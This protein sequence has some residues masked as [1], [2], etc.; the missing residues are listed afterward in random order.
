MDQLPDGLA[1]AVELWLHSR[2]PEMETGP[3]AVYSTRRPDVSHEHEIL[4][5]SVPRFRWRRGAEVTVLMQTR[6][7]CRV[8]NPS[9]GRE[10]ASD[11]TI[12]GTAWRMT[13][14][15]WRASDIRTDRWVS[16]AVCLK[17]GRQVGE[18]IGVRQV[19]LS[20]R[21]YENLVLFAL[22]NVSDTAAALGCACRQAL[23]S[24]A[25]GFGGHKHFEFTLPAG[26]ERIIAMRVFPQQIGV[27][28][29]FAV[30]RTSLDGF[31]GPVVGEPGDLSGGEIL[32][33]PSVTGPDSNR[34][35]VSDEQRPN[36]LKM[37]IWG[38]R[39]LPV[40]RGW[41]Q[42]SVHAQPIQ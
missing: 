40:G 8:W 38:H 7:A 41:C 35:P 14:D 39:R 37:P 25:S 22:T 26:G 1:D 16:R 27:D 5:H 23:R 11:F 20:C 17:Q 15:G 42:H 36:L 30:R 10:E 18:I 31:P 33:N 13:N 6:L 28:V 24:A 19:A 12:T 9:T 2:S 4:A 3:L 21:V 32:V 34:H 29:P